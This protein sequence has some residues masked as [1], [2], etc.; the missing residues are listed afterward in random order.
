MPL[1]LRILHLWYWMSFRTVLGTFDFLLLLPAKHSSPPAP[2][3][4]VY[5]HARSSC[6]SSWMVLPVAPFSLA[7]NTNTYCVFSIKETMLKLNQPF[8][9]WSDGLLGTQ[10][11]PV[12][13]QHQWL[14]TLVN[15]LIHICSNNVMKISVQDV[16]D[17]LFDYACIHFTEEELFFIKSPYP[18]LLLRSCLNGYELHGEG[19]TPKSA[20]SVNGFQCVR[21]RSFWIR[22]R[23]SVLNWI[24]RMRVHSVRRHWITWFR[25]WPIIFAW[26]M[27][28]RLSSLIRRNKWL[29]RV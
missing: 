12:D 23:K 26:W 7:V 11:A 14:L 8:I 17:A 2:V 27:Y 1:S 3:G 21:N 18:L 9:D 16:I 15:I 5:F 6:L 25:G 10:F 22:S 19:G 24:C 28:I 29:M 4:L 20:Q 13:R